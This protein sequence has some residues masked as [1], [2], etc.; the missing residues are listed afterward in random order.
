MPPTMNLCVYYSPM[1]SATRI[2]WAL[3]ELGV[4]YDK[5]KLDLT[6]GEQK[7]P[8]YLKLNPN[9][10]VP[11]LV[12]DGT[13]IFESVAILC[14][15]GETFGESAGLFPAP[16][17]S[18][19]KAFQWMA[20]AGVTLGEVVSRYLRN[21]LDRFPEEQRNASAAA[22]AKEEFSALIAILESELSR[23][24]FLLGSAFTLSDLPAFGYAAFG[25]RLGM[26]NLE[27]YPNVNAWVGRC[28]SREALRR[29]QAM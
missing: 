5:V 6:Q 15:L 3:E 29:A 11:L 7:S 17:L 20:W 12:A 23:S 19:A 13:P 9:G 27:D 26:L 16:G 25:K 28:S 22:V 21:T 1:S 2:L 18:R 10:K 8:E 14:F 4:P 24:D